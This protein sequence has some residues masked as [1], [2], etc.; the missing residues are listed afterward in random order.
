MRK[1]L[2]TLGLLAA[3]SAPTIAA[4]YSEGVR[5]NDYS[6]MQFNIMHVLDEKPGDIDH[7][8]LEMEFG[9]RSGI[10]DLYGYVDLFNPTNN[11]TSAKDGADRLFMKFNP[12]MSLDAAT[13]ADLSFGP[14]Q[15]LYIASENIIDGGDNGY[16]TK[17]GIGSD[18]MVPWFG[19]MQFNLYARHE[20]TSHEWNGYQ[21]STNWFKPFVNFENGSFIS[22]QGYLD[23]EFGMDDDADNLSGHGGAMYNGIYW[24]Y[25]NYAVGYG[26]KLYN[27]VYGLQ[28][29][30]YFDNKAP[31]DGRFSTS[32]V[33][34]YFA[35][36]YKF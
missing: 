20:L 36:T 1:S 28:D 22:Y 9:G 21:I 2:L 17:W 18:I 8:Y 29:G 35:A 31:E 6:W 23:Y 14:L 26:L 12:R 11:S 16:T 13:G 30:A 5:S 3:T 4:D 32:G 7:T 10:F 33:A 25:K 19:K 34:H 27:N 15:E 24:H